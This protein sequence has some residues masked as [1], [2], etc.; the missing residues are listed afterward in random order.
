MKDYVGVRIMENFE[1]NAPG[2]PVESRMT[3]MCKAR[4]EDQ[5]MLSIIRIVLWKAGCDRRTCECCR[6]E[7]ICFHHGL[8]HV[9][10]QVPGK[11]RFRT[12]LKCLSGR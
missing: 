1:G 7:I 4:V 12:S 8:H 11:S 3:R 10:L 2:V 5:L 6:I 9:V